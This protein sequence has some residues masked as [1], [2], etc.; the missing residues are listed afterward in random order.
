[1]KRPLYLNL[2]QDPTTFDPRKAADLP[3]STVTFFLYEGL[4]RSTT[5]SIYAPALAES[6]EESNGGKTY[7][8]RLKKAYWSDQQP[9]TAYDFERSWK[10]IL[11]PKFPCPNAHLFYPIQGAE[12]AKRGLIPVDAVGVKALD[13]QT[14]RVDL[15]QPTPYFVELTA[16][17][18][19]FPYKEGTDGTPLFSGSYCL[20][21]F[22]PKNYL[23]LEKNRLYWNQSQ[24]KLDAMRFFLIE[25]GMTALEM[26]ER[27]EI[28]IIGSSFTAL[29]TESIPI[30]KKQYDIQS[31]ETAGTAFLTFN[32]LSKF[33]KNEKM[34]QAFIYS[35][36]RD[37]IIEHLTFMDEKVADRLL[38][39]MLMTEKKEIP[40]WSINRE[41]AV[42]LFNEALSELG[43]KKEEVKIHFTL[44]SSSNSSNFQ[45]IAQVIQEQIRINLGIHVQIDLLEMKVYLEQ[46]YKHNYDMAGCLILAQYLD[47]LAYLD[48]FKTKT[49]LRNYPCFENEEYTRLIEASFF[50]SS[51]EERQ[52][53]IEKAEQILMDSGTLFPIYHFRNS[54][55]V[56][57]RVKNLKT[58]P[59][60]TLCLE[61]VE[62]S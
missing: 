60:G 35:I 12:E 24:I 53:I 5:N 34:R 43:M 9:I 33:F 27:G 52:E 6:I 40:N 15:A 1:M 23:D 4:T 29:P 61:E 17:C 36:D 25:E 30:L 28:D 38:P 8:F 59:Q 26:F 48:R 11:N 57:K 39:P 41:K 31:V 47:P 32:T 14:L 37:E 20:K 3:S 2:T 50:A 18:T 21:E 46:L 56:S 22:R 19:F 58:F 44:S 7:I 54:F 13:E 62:L 42:I 51:K 49:H 45:K 16:F 55:A 10:E